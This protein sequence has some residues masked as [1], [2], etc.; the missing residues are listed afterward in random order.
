MTAILI[1]DELIA[2]IVFIGGDAWLA[3]SPVTLG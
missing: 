1:L 2:D 3:N